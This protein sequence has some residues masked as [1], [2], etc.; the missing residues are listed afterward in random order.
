MLWRDIV[1]PAWVTVIWFC[2]SIGGSR[3]CTVRCRGHRRG[4]FIQCTMKTS[5]SLSKKTIESTCANLNYAHTP[6]IIRRFT[7]VIVPRSATLESRQALQHRLSPCSSPEV[8]LSIRAWEYV[9]TDVSHRRGT[10]L[11]SVDTVGNRT[12]S[13]N[14]WI[15]K[16]GLAL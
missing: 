3:I 5:S 13:A 14:V 6:M 11:V 4:N 2:W 9:V 1:C 16:S 10:L 15:G 12:A 7:G 8:R